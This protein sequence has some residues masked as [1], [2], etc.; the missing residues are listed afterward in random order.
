MAASELYGW[1]A[2]ELLVALREAQDDL[3]SGSSLTDAG[4]GDVSTR[5]MVVANA[6]ERIATIQK[7][8]YELDPTTYAAFALV[9]FTQVRAVFS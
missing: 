4:S 8:L 7:A 3:L 9:G 5:R 2:P 1:T 6:Q